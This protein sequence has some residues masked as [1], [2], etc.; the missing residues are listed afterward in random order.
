MTIRLLTSIWYALLL[1]SLSGLRETALAVVSCQDLITPGGAYRYGDALTLFTEYKGRTYAIAKSAVSGVTT[2]PDSYFTLTAGISREYAMTGV[3][4]ASLKK[5][6]ALG[7]YGAARPVTIDSLDLQNFLL[8]RYG[9]YLGAADSPASSYV[10]AWKEFNQVGFSRIDGTPLSYTNWGGPVFAGP[11]PQA[12][13]IGSDGVWTSGL[14]GAR[15]AQIVELP[16][17]K[18]SQG[19]NSNILVDRSDPFP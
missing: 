3:D 5:L 12:V 16:G 13:V 11:E 8:S 17:R 18:Q 9:T 10:N 2:L 19:G 6:L 14:D 4:T 7:N 15:T 1:L